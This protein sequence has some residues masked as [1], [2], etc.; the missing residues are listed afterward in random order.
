M[1]RS[2]ATPAKLNNVAYL[3]VTVHVPIAVHHPLRCGDVLASQG[4]LSISMD[5]LVLGKTPKGFQLG[6]LDQIMLFN[7]IHAILQTGH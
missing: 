4:T 1:R 5:S 7:V 3:I 2:I 6:V